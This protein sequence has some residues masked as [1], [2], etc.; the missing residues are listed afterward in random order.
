MVKAGILLIY[1]RFEP[2][3]K[4]LNPNVHNIIGNTFGVRPINS[5]VIVIINLT[6]K[7]NFCQCF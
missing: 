7:I 3:L 6:L 5:H 4:Q 1:V 2:K